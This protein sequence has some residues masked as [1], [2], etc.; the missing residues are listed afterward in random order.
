MDNKKGIIYTAINKRRITL[1]V[2]VIIFIAG[3]LSY[4]SLP[5]QQ[6]PVIKIPMVIIYTVY[7]GAS[8]TD[9]E[10]LVTSKIE[11][12]CMATDGF[13]NVRSDSYN[14][15]SVVKVMFDRSLS[16]EDLQKDMDKLRNSINDLKEN[17]LPSGITKLTFNDDAFDTSGYL[18]ALTSETESNEALVERAEKL[19]DILIGI[20]GVSNAEVEGEI[21]R[22]VKVTVNSDKLNHISL[23]L[24]ELSSIIGY[25][26]SIVPVGTIKFNSDELFINTSGKFSDL[27]EIKNIIISV[28]SDTGAIVKLRDVATVEEVYNDSSK[29]YTYNGEPAVILSLYFNEGVNVID[30]GESVVKEVENYQKTLPEGVSIN[31]VVY[32]PD[33]VS[34]SINDFIINLIE[35]VAI[36]LI[37]I[38][39]GMSI[40]NG[41]IVAVVIPLT[42]FISFIA[43]KAFGVDVQFVS[44]A[45]LIIALGMLVSNAIVVSDA[46]QVRIDN[47]ED[48]LS[49]C[50][51]GTKEVAFPV[52]TSTLTTVV[53]FAV[54][55]FLPGTMRRFA[56]SLPTV[57][58]SALTASYVVS[59]LV[60]PIMCYIKM[61]KT[62]EKK[63]KKQ[64][65]KAFFSFLLKICMKARILTLLISTIL[66]AGAIFLLTKIDLELIPNS[67]KML[68]DVAI[69]TDNFYDIRK[70]ETA[71]SKAQEIISSYAE[72]EYYLAVSGGHIPKYEFT[73]SPS[74]DSTNTGN[75]VIKI[76]LKN[77][78]LTSNKAEFCKILGERLNSEISDCQVVVKEMGIIPNSSEPIQINVCGEDFNALN[79]TATNIENLL[80][81]T[82]GT[83]D[84]HSDRKIKTYDYFIEMKNDALN[85][86]GLTKAEV[87]NEL[88]IA[89]MG[90]ESTIFRKNNKEYPVI[91]ES[92]IKDMD[93]LSDLKIK[94]STT[95][96]K[97]KLKQIAD[98]GINNDYNSISHFNGKRC[99]TVTAGVKD[100][101]SAINIQNNI[102][103]KIQNSSGVE[104]EYEG[105]NDMFEEIIKALG[106]GSLLGTIVI[107]LILYVQ[108]YSFRK[109]VIVL[110]SIPFGLIG[111]A[112][113]LYLTGQNLSI[114][115]I[116]GIVS[117]IGVVVNNAIV[118][119]DYMDNEV[120]NGANINDACCTAVDMRFRPILLSTVTTVLGLFPLV[121]SGNVLFTG[122]S[123]AFMSGL[124]A[125][126][127]FTFIAIPICYSLLIKEKN[128]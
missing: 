116:L 122:L 103:S 64:R 89:M 52:L 77:S 30:V 37:V 44:L 45:S 24:A 128:E 126:M 17:E 18:V 41:S 6:Y 46:I 92:D 13:L 47:D 70:T 19:K 3:L 54:F 36:V 114:F 100:G 9:M 95:K 56:F 118:L 90:R 58:I 67:D 65:M 97:Y 125:S 63:L 120:K 68:L 32:L 69:T 115:A 51:N 105:D 101:A 57:V 104:I 12:T 21:E 108:F 109:S 86:C 123:I 72:T 110:V 66:V 76:N 88:N 117:L 60:T 107:F 79:E 113:G 15:T 34:A 59:M 10:E 62:P 43:M 121:L 31:K 91:V 8:A 4:I 23:S 80:F 82:S 35:S 93:L 7:P 5:K 99:V 127:F 87:Q 94:S 16:E 55:Y 48:R 25:Q 11:D 96:G 74:T 73:T 112:V 22:Q 26:N 102:K 33:D 111:S 42:I 75:I 50:I 40:T 39:I 1:F 81:E 38:M 78:G 28:N 106:I 14:S 71:I 49:A 85:S 27:E 53:I 84:V 61:K 29:K 2:I 83:K 98:I 124:L 119:V 20:D